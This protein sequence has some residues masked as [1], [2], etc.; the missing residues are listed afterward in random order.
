MRAMLL[1]LGL[2]LG[3]AQTAAA[4]EPQALG[5]TVT[6]IDGNEVK[7]SD[8]QGKVILVVN[9]ASRCGLTPQY[10]SLQAMYDKYKDQ[11]FVILAFPC[12]QFG[13]QEPGTSAEIKQFCTGEYNVTFPLFAKVDVNGDGA[14]D[15]YK[16][17]TALETEPKGAGAI[18]WNFEKF[19]IGRDG[20]VINRFQPRTSPTDADFV[21]AVE[22]ALA[23]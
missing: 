6:D 14:S 19:L 3:L 22:G 18:S 7:L 11:G 1:A 12:N 20:Q 4:D 16:Y 21:S 2:M 23:K 13:A 5:Y 10:E 15:L 17:L 8:Y 9:V